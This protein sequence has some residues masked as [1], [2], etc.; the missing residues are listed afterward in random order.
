MA[1]VFS[2]ELAIYFVLP[3]FLLF[4]AAFFS[5][6]IFVLIAQTVVERDIK[7][8][9]GVTAM[10]ILIGAT[11]SGSLSAYWVTQRLSVA[12]VSAPVIFF[13]VGGIACGRLLQ[14]HC[15]ACTKRRFGPIGFRRG[16]VVS[17]LLSACTIVPISFVAWFATQLK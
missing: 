2:L 8:D 4:V 9:T 11:M 15:Y 13:A 12:I 5:A 1:D 17:A 7:R 10:A 3:P 16:F 14:D 6:D